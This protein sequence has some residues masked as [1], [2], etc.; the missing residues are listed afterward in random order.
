MTSEDINQLEQM[1]ELEDAF[2]EFDEEEPYIDAPK[3]SVQQEQQELTDY[4][5]REFTEQELNELHEKALILNDL[6][7]KSLARQRGINGHIIFP[8]GSVG[9]YTPDN[10][11]VW[12]ESARDILRQYQD[13]QPQ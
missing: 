5:D 2:H 3:Q 10:V 9:A 7:D 1:M 12:N 13:S 4:E 11:Q 8:D 6:Y